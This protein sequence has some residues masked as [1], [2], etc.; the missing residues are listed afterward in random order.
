MTE[1]AAETRSSGRVPH[2]RSLSRTLYGRLAAL[3]FGLCLLLGGLYTA[4]MVRT[5]QLY[6]QEVNQKLNRNLA[7]HLA[8]ERILLTDGR[9]NKEAA[10]ETFR[11]LMAIN[12]S[13]EIYLLD[14]EGRVLAF[15]AAPGVVKR[16]RVSL[17]PVRAMLDER[18]LPIYGDDPRS[19]TRRKVFSVTALRRARGGQPVPPNSALDGYLYVILVGEEYVSALGLVGQSR[20]L[21]SSAWTVGLLI[22]LALLAALLIV[23]GL[24]RRLTRLAREM[25]AFRES[26]FS[27][28]PALPSEA[29]PPGDEIDTL[30]VTFR[31]MSQRIVGQ[32][33]HLR[34]VDRLRRDLVANV[35][36]DLRTPMASIHGYLETLL[37]KGPA[38]A[39]EERKRYLEVALK[40]SQGLRTMVDE[41]FD[42]A[43]LDAREVTMHQEPFSLCELGQDV[44]Q[45]FELLAAGKGVELES[46]LSPS[47]PMVV[48]DIQLIERVLLNLVQNAVR[49][50]RHGGCVSL[51]CHMD[52]ARVLVEVADTGPGIS[53]D[54]L[55]HIFERFYRARGAD[56]EAV[57][58]AGLGLAIAKHIVELHGTTLGVRSAPEAGATFT[59]TL[60]V[61]EV[62]PAP[63]TIAG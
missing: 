51:N 39:P 10:A 22:A 49:H 1:E 29:G 20:T 50:T 19:E 24:T 16:D 34:E 48:A 14:P 59:F 28:I 36:H 33:G 21:R 38:L 58:G 40:H 62:P 53:A 45:R 35:S 23:R 56:N 31:D 6:L 44:L 13:I 41:L 30:A 61:A 17:E 4:W 7:R 57:Q 12:R 43:K 27:R 5:S 18:P 42:L 52:G 3:L 37:L 15:S 55:P 25:A 9:I 63:T 46:L 32:I 47:L 2:R 26:D 60:Q 54:E 8:A 11:T